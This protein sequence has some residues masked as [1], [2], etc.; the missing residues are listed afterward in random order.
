MI[1]GKIDVTKIDKTKLFKGKP[2]KDGKCPMYLDIALIETKRSGFGDWRDDNTHMI[3]QSVTMEER[4]AGKRGAILGNAQDRS[5]KRTND[6]QP[7]DPAST[8]PNDH[9]PSIEG[10]GDD[11]PF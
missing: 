10:D 5:S 6:Q 1:T 4:A 2:G 9:L 7:A 3:V 11:V 8:D